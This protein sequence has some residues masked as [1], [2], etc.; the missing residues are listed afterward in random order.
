MIL[1][2][3]GFIESHLDTI[4]TYVV[5]FAFVGVDT[6]MKSATGQKDFSGVPA[7]ASMAGLSLFAGTAATL[8]ARN[9]VPGRATVVAVM[10]F[11]AGIFCW[12][13]CLKRAETQRKGKKE[14]TVI[15]PDLRS[16]IL[17]VIVVALCWNGSRY[18]LNHFSFPI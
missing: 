18:L 17:G 13:K 10:A 4:L 15:K 6:S 8:I 5:P 11:F 2:P 1:D 16:Y 9:M 3:F 7:D 12:F 14:G